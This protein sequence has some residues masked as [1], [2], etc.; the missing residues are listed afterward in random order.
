[1]G[2]TSSGVG[3]AVLV[4]SKSTLI[5]LVGDSDGAALGSTLVEGWKLME[6]DTL[7]KGLTVGS[8]EPVAV[9][10]HMMLDIK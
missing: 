7:G 4:G 3:D 6:G 8:G 10:G 1:M 2:D 9:K 5:N